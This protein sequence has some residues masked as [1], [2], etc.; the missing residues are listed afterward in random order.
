MRDPYDV[1][2]VPRDA[3]GDAI[4]KAYR[5]RARS[6]H[7]DSH[8]GDADAEEMFKELATAY[9]LLSN[10]EMRARFDR[11]EIAGS[12][13]RPRGPA[14][15]HADNRFDQFLRRRRAR[16]RGGI[17]VRG[18]DVTYTLTVSFLDAALGTSRRVDMASGKRLDIRV[19]PGTGD[20]QILR[21]QGQGMAGMGGG[22]DGD[23]LV[24]VRVEED[25]RFRR[26]GD[27]IHVE[28]F[29][30]LPEAVLG[31]SIEVPT[32][33]GPVAMTVPEGSNTGTVLRLKGR[34]MTNG[35]GGRGEQYVTLKVVLPD[36]PDKALVEFVRRW[37][38]DNDYR[39][40]RRTTG[41]D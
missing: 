26:D 14:W 12:G 13:D 17:K 11:G 41:V 24:E 25:D 5:Q 32:I 16:R 38:R 9:D 6:L 8:P 21:L 2:G 7:P 34:G 29:V 39:V 4:K 27:D 1:L 3:S 20:G 31:A 23:A 37:S 15:P 28:A 19:P 33:D 40:R 30:T 36:K 10:R 35:D 18:A 22:E